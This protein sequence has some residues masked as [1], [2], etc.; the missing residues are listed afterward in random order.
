MVARGKDGEK[1]QEVWD[2]RV[3]TAVFRM[4]NLQE[5]TVYGTGKSAQCYVTAWMGGEL[6]E[7]GYI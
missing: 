6:G 4:D 2:Q 1:R 5:P 3:H 7:N